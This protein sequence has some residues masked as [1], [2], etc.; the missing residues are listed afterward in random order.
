[1]RALG[2]VVQLFAG[3]ELFKGWEGATRCFG[4]VDVLLYTRPDRN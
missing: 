1:M 2:C 4:S 3:R